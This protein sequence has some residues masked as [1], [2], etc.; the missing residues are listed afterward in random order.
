[1]DGDKM[2]LDKFGYKDETESSIGGQVSEKIQQV[3]GKL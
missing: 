2:I 1:M 3:A